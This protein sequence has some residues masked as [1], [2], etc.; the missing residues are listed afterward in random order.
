MMRNMGYANVWAPSRVGG[1]DSWS[2][3]PI[4]QLREGGANAARLFKEPW[5]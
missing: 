3:R 2:L 4:A 5:T 1:V